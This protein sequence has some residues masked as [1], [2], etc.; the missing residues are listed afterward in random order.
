MDA[1]GRKSFKDMCAGARSRKIRTDSSLSSNV[2]VIGGKSLSGV[3]A[4]ENRG[5]R[6]EALRMGKPCIL[7]KR[8]RKEW[9]HS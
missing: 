5:E 1:R 6:L 3:D 2:V 7:L 9:A 4:K 8:E